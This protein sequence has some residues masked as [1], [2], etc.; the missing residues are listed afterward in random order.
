MRLVPGTDPRAHKSCAV[1]GCKGK[2]KGKGE[3]HIVADADAAIHC[4]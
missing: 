4:W 2:G 3:V 1:I